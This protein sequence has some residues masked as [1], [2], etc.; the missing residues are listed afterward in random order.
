MNYKNGDLT[1]YG[2]MQ[3]ALNGGTFVEG[4]L[5]EIT[6]NAALEL[7][8]KEI[9]KN[10]TSMFLAECT[11]RLVQ[12]STLFSRCLTMGI[13]IKQNKKINRRNSI[14]YSPANS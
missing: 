13:P 5:A 11:Y 6:D 14:T 7:Y 1:E 3:D 8:T 2:L 10:R 12:K 4:L 9:V